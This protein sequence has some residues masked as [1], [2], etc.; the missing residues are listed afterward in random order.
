MEKRNEETMKDLFLDRLQYEAHIWYICP[1]S[2]KDSETLMQLKTV[3]SSD[4]LE[5]YQRFYFSEDSHR[6]LVS[7]ALVRHVL[8]KYEAISPSEWVFVCTPRGRP[9]IA[10]LD[11]SALR[12]NLTHTTGLV[13][14][15]VSLDHDCG[16]DAEYIVERRDLL[17]VAQ[18]MFSDIEFGELQQ[19]TGQEQLEYFFS[20]WTLREAYVKATGI[21]ISFPTSKLL[22]ECKGDLMIRLEFDPKL[23]DDSG[24]WQF[25]LLRPS[26]QH[27]TA[28]ALRR[29]QHPA[30]KI[31]TRFFKY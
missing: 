28:I 15:I 4:E 26:H 11:V 31:V 8:S 17:G 13:A 29:G 23:D 22:F 27:I 16:I 14:C 5:Q 25:S 21:G 9:E 30:K 12:F 2:I 3:L 20:R 18:K 10:N 24:H 6:Y 7:H 1:E 19:L